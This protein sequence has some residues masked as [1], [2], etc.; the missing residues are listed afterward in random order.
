[1][2]THRKV[3]RPVRHQVVHPQAAGP[4][5]AK[6]VNAASSNQIFDPADTN[7]DGT[8]SATERLAYAS[9]QQTLGATASLNST[10]TPTS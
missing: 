7:Q 4:A 8:V 9:K 6:G 5:G 2:A 10:N 1:M 3:V